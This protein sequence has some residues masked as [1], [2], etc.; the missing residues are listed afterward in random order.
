[1]IV[2][3]AQL[4]GCGRHEIPTVSQAKCN[5][6]Q[7]CLKA[8][9]KESQ[10]QAATLTQQCCQ[11]ESPNRRVIIVGNGIAG[12]AAALNITVDPPQDAPNLGLDPRI[13]VYGSPSFWQRLDGLPAVWQT[14]L[15][16]PF[17][18]ACLPDPSAFNASGASLRIP[19]PSVQVVNMEALL[20]AEADYLE[21]GPVAISQT[22]D[23]HWLIIDAEGR[24]EV[25]D[26]ALIV[27][28]GLLRPLRFTDLIPGRQ[29][30]DTRLT[31]RQNQ[32]ILSGDE[33]LAKTPNVRG[34]VVGVLGAGGNSADVVNRA[35]SPEVGAKEVV[36]WG[37]VPPELSKTRSFQDNETR[38]KSIMCRVKG[39]VTSVTYASNTVQVTATASV[40][41]ETGA[42]PSVPELLVESLGRYE[43]DP[44]SEVVKAARDRRIAYKPI[45]DQD[46]ALIAVRV[47]F[48][49]DER[50]VPMYLIGAA[51]TWIPPGVEITA[52]DLNAY[53]KGVEK[54]LQKV[55]A[56]ATNPENPPPGFAVAAFMGS[57]LGRLLSRK[58]VSPCP[59]TN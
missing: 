13:R 9:Q 39:N 34:K 56:D 1:M 14:S 48:D 59:P 33:F 45:L 2:L 5:T 24:R 54:T 3:L 30:R 21:S 32:R 28:T 15:D 25:A 26:K 10:K 4:A 52:A 16:A 6:E 49:N 58:T 36:V 41:Q 42:P 38:W 12:A 50:A 31:L 46:N 17:R 22:K 37:G 7:D 20:R 47:F 11:A 55:N 44:P 18:A 43:G 51:A 19:R 23:G 57:E 35:L 53:T 8:L 27:A 40:C 29:A